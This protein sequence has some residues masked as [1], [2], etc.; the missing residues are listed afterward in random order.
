MKS[1]LFC[2]TVVCGPGSLYM[3]LQSAPIINCVSVYIMYDLSNIV[4]TTCG[5][6]VACYIVY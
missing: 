1:M 4:L 6:Y 5:M 2:I 3:C